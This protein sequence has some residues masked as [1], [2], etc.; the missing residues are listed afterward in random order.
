[1]SQLD[2]HPGQQKQ[3][4]IPKAA[5]L[6][7]MQLRRQIVRHELAEGASLPSESALVAEFNVS[8]PTLREAYRILESEGLLTVR[9]GARGGAKVHA[10]NVAMAGR[11]AALVLESQGTVLSDIYDARLLL[12]GPM[13]RMVAENPSP[14]GLNRLDEINRAAASSV[15]DPVKMAE[16]HHAFHNELL[17]QASNQ[18][19]K[20]LSGMIDHILE[21]AHFL[22]V[23]NAADTSGVQRAQ[24][25]HEQL[26]TLIRAGD[27]EATDSLWTSHLAAQGEHVLA[28]TSA[29]T[30]LD[31]VG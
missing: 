5:E 4:R 1:M 25:T 19:V 26:V 23:S 16:W 2:A 9:R 14:E 20:L 24:R 17:S 15:D 28:H 27:V 12:E 3:I 30:P 21:R 13:A 10:P 18:T 31:I 29:K 8:R 22:Y 7:A 11:Y 6:I